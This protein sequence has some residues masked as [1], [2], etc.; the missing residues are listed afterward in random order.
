MEEKNINQ[1]EEFEIDLRRLFGALVNKAWFIG[2][3]AVLCAA[4]SFAYTFF[5]VTPLYQSS[6]MFYV[7]NS[8]IN[9]GEAS[10]SISSADISG[11]LAENV[12]PNPQQL[13]SS[14]DCV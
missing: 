7:N 5:F 1:N 9:L 2:I 8:S 14:S 3:V 11:N 10:L 4:L 6:A 13:S 12:P